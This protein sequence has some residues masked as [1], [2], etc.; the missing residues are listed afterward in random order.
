M[1]KT[2]IKV[3]NDDANCMRAFNAYYDCAFI[4]DQEIEQKNIK[5]FQKMADDFNN[6]I[7][8][9]LAISLEVVE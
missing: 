1:T 4:I 8:Y 2:I 6:Q 5:Q 9:G 3:Y 7:A